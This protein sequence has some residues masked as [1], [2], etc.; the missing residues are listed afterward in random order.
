MGGHHVQFDVLS[1]EA[2]RAALQSPERYQGLIVRGAGYGDYFVR[3][4]RGLQD[5]IIS[6]TDHGW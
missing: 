2:L 5:E 1:G 4:G 3:L 6:R